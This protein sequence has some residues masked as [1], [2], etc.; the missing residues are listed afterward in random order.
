MTGHEESGTGSRVTMLSKPVHGSSLLVVVTR[1]LTLGVCF[2]GGGGVTRSLMILLSRGRLAFVRPWRIR[3]VSA[4]SRRSSRTGVLICMRKAIA[5][6]PRKWILHGSSKGTHSG[7]R[8][9]YGR[10]RS[11]FWGVIVSRSVMTGPTASSFSGG[12]LS[13]PRP[14]PGGVGSRDRVQRPSTGVHLGH[15][16][17]LN[18]LPHRRW[19]VLRLQ[20]G[21]R[22]KVRIR[23]RRG[24][25]G[26][27]L[28]VRVQR[29]RLVC[30]RRVDRFSW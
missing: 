25:L 2:S 22:S 12:V 21:G 7:K 10:S 18:I 5:H 29:W 9:H 15:G 17:K 14:V 30:Q 28:L 27:L 16:R 11:L 19:M 20:C 24:R 13:R 26:S 6:L 8:F 23:W 3:G 4:G 1:A